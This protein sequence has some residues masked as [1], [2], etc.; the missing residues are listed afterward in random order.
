MIDLKTAWEQIG[1][2]NKLRLHR[3]TEKNNIKITKKCSKIIS[4]LEQTLQ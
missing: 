3:I 2:Q 1:W 4:K